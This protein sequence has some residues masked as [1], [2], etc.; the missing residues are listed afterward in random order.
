MAAM[1]ASLVVA[2]SIMLT[3]IARQE[4]EPR[5]AAL[6]AQLQELEIRDKAVTDGTD[7]QKSF[8]TLDTLPELRDLLGRV[9]DSQIRENVL[10]ALQ[11]DSQRAATRNLQRCHE[12]LSVVLATLN[13]VRTAL[14]EW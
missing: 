7:D 13:K 2:V 4:M 3:K 6:N 5:I 14:A 8:V 10:K 9:T 12:E 1:V 11:E